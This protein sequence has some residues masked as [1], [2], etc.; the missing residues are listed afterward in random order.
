LNYL[1]RFSIDKLKIDQSFIRDIPANNDSMTIVSAI[2]AM[3]KELNVRTLAEGVETEEQLA[4][5]RS[6]DCGYV[7]GYYFS[8]ALEKKFFT[9]LL[10]NHQ[11]MA[12]AEAK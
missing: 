8:K 12:V 9:Q 4:F 6:K 2:L 5:L 7:Q 10:L 1:K 3:A 11:G